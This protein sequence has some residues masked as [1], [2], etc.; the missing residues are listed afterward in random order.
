MT[1]RELI[2]SSNVNEAIKAIL[3]LFIIIIIIIIILQ[4]DFTHTESTKR[5]Q[6]NKNKKDSIFIRIKTSKRKKIVCLT[7]CA[8]LYLLMFFMIFMRIK[9]I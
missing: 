8:F 2:V 3:N 1:T 6:A 4:E 9:N 5:I 7:F